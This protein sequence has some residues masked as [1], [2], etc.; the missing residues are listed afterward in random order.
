LSTTDDNIVGSNTL[1][2]AIRNEKGPDSLKAPSGSAGY[3]LEPPGTPLAGWQPRPDG[4]RP[5]FLKLRL[6]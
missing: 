1:W 5:N 2:E 6:L 3:H 4:S